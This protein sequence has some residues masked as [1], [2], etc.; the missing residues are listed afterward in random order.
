VSG[1]TG[2]PEPAQPVFARYWLH[3]KGQAPAGNL[4]VAV[5]L[6]PTR[7]AIPVSPT[8]AP[9]NRL[10]LTVACGP[11]PASGV[12]EL[13]VPD[14]LVVQPGG[15]LAYELPPLG[16]AEWE[17]SVRG[18][19]G[20]AVGHYFLAA[21]IRDQ[22]GQVIEDAA[23]VH[24][25]LPPAPA[26]TL[27][28]AELVPAVQADQQAIAAELDV[29]VLTP[30]LR[31]AAGQHGELAVRVASRAASPIRGEAQLISPFGSWPAMQPWTRGFAVSPGKEIT[32]RYHVGVPVTTR[33]GTQWWTMVKL[34]YFGRLHYTSAVPVDV[35][36]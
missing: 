34:M 19:P 27:P 26:L 3:G 18:A 9:A 25:G 2:L 21:R 16:F 6:S 14:G 29:T 4:P 28:L 7:L 35:R 13:D 11:E 1:V 8:S 30:A 20:A 31:V 23:A 5:H 15:A 33:R 36:E 10:R 12:V 24:L 32:L 17:L 22:L